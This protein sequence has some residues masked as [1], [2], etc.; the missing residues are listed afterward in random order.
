MVRQ[1][2]FG[3][4]VLLNGFSP[5]GYVK[6]GT[7]S[8]ALSICNRTVTDSRRWDQG[9]RSKIAIIIEGREGLCVEEQAKTQQEWAQRPVSVNMK[10]T[11]RP[12]RHDNPAS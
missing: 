11:R 1:A 2:R 8:T 4:S 9:K 3:V 10:G 12:R 5:A 6:F 7:K